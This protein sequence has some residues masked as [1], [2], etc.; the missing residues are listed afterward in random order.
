MLNKEIPFDICTG[1]HCD[2]QFDAVIKVSAR[3][4]TASGKLLS[5]GPFLNLHSYF[6]ANFRS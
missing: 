1:N 5:Y 2:A 6:S 3:N 4:L